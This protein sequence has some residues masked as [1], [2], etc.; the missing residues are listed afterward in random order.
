MAAPAEVTAIGATFVE[1]TAAG[2]RAFFARLVE[3]AGR[4][5]GAFEQELCV[6]RGDLPT[7][8][9]PYVNPRRAGEIWFGKV[10]LPDLVT[11]ED[12]Y[13]IYAAILDPVA[14]RFGLTSRHQISGR[15]G[16][17]YTSSDEGF[18]VFIG[19][20]RPRDSAA[21]TSTFVPRLVYLP[22]PGDDQANRIVRNIWRRPCTKWP[23][24]EGC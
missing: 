16:T 12:V 20:L 18:S 14:R 23:W 8:G 17:H 6:I 15:D 21:V 1:R 11:T 22:A 10:G 7:L 19:E 4:D 9:Y 3:G 5:A 24:Y 2:A 13:R